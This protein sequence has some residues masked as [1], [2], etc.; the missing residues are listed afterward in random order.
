MRRS[1]GRGPAAD[2]VA[3]LGT[4]LVVGAVCGVLWWLAVDPAEY[5]RTRRGGGA[6]GEVDLSKRFN[7]DGWYA[8]IA[9]V[10]GFLS[11]VWLSWWRQRDFRL[12]TL[13][14]V[15][16]AALAAAAMAFVGG[17]VG[18][19]DPDAALSQAQPGDTV[20]VALEVLAT[21]TYLTWPIAVLFGALMVLWSSP[22]VPEP[23]R[24]AVQTDEQP[25]RGTAPEDHGHTEHSPR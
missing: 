18:P 10:A 5:T 24:G 14:L 7:A 15:P 11:G 12:T 6:M 19:G 4:L 9:I 3:V 23:P 20:P 21:S 2:V 16:G 8:V 1:L 25:P 13:L 17:L 22:G